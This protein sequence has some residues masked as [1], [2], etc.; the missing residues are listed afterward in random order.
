[1]GL[2]LNSI[3]LSVPLSG[4]LN[5]HFL[6]FSHG[7]YFYSLFQN[8]INAELLQQLDRSVPLLLSAATQSPSMVRSLAWNKE[9][10]QKDILPLQ[11]RLFSSFSVFRCIVCIR[12]Y[13]LCMHECLLF[14]R[15]VSSSMACWTTVSVSALSERL[16]AHDCPNKY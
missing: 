5:P 4:S 1:M 2:L 7:E 14:L 11:Q 9:K 16:K 8:T 10:E 13:V 6:S 12:H 15:L 3:T